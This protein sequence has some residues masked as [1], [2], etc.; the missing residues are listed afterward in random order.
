MAKIKT[1]F[2]ANL[3][4][5]ALPLVRLMNKSRGDGE[6]MEDHALCDRFIFSQQNDSLLITP[7]LIDKDFFLDSSN[8]LNLKN[9]VNLAPEQVEESLCQAIL[10]NDKLL[11]VILGQ[12][13]ELDIISYA[14]TP[15]FLELMDYLKKK[16]LKFTTSE[17][18][19]KE[20]LWVQDFFDSKAGFRQMAT[21]IPGLPPMPQGVI[22]DNKE[23]IFGWANYFLNKFGGCVVKTNR[24]LAG[25]GLK[26]I[27]N[28]SD[29]V[30][31]ERYWDQETVVVE[32]F[33]AP[34]LSVCGGSPNIELRIKNDKVE[35]LYVCSMRID[36]NGVF[37]GVELGKEAVP[38]KVSNLLEKTG[39]EFG[40]LLHKYGYRGFFET[41]WVYGKDDI[42][43]PIEANLRRTGGTH[44][45][46]L[47][48]RLLGKEFLKNYYVVATNSAPVQNIHNYSEFKAKTQDLF[49]IIPTI[50]NYLPYGKV[51]YV[52]YG[53]D[54]NEVKEIETRFLDRIS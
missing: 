21:I 27:K 14:A 16:G 32:K 23:E 38:E 48:S 10:K 46:E 42:C 1:I 52:V 41:D 40:A 51:G 12:D 44:V 22:C 11:K 43:Y 34:D 29:L 18:P 26:I 3:A 50:M 8:L 5:I 30:F 33:V 47:G 25:A 7:F 37:K 2:V 36:N 15:E 24:G 49:G 19:E 9:V 35:P 39:L 4:E 17:A 31:D 13:Q 54:K 20:N 6:I 28:K 45:Y 53:Q